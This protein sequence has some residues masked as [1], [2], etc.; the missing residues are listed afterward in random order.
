MA[1][2]ATLSEVCVRHKAGDPR[3]EPSIGTC[4]T[5][6]G[7]EHIE[8]NSGRRIWLCDHQ[9]GRPDKSEADFRAVV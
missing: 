8:P 1:N 6:V 3:R 4:R 7:L 9:L 2:A 5:F